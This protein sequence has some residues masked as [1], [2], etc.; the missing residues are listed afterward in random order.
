M[1]SR[2]MSQAASGELRVANHEG[3]AA[4][5]PAGVSVSVSLPYEWQTVLQLGYA[6][7][8]LHDAATVAYWAN[9]SESVRRIHMEDIAAQA[10]RIAEL[11][12]KLRAGPGEGAACVNHPDRPP[13]ANLDGDYLCQECADAWVRGEGQAAAQ[14]EAEDEVL[15]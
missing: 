8:A 6:G 14:R 15:F 3:E 10:E 4:P 13:C 9:E 11:I 7:Q 2:D 1:S 12:E 5:A